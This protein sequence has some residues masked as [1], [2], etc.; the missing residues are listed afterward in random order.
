VRQVALTAGGR[1]LADEIIAARLEG[2][3]RFAASL[4][5]SERGK[6]TEALDALLEREPIAEIHRT[7][8][9]ARRRR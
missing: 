3:E 5:R 8:P 7:Y 4:S 6:L 1:D 9:R 2:L